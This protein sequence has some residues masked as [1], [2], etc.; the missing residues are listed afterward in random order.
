MAPSST[1][2]TRLT[3]LTP[4]VRGEGLCF[5]PPLAVSSLSQLPTRAL[6]PSLFH[7][8]L[9][10]CLRGLTPYPFPSTPEE[11]RGHLTLQGPC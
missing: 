3:A 5:C 7:V 1:S 2:S 10:L 6:W 9:G 8:T 4:P 11:A